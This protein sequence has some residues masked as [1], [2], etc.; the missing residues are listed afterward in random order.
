M[1]KSEILPEVVVPESPAASF[2]CLDT[3]KH[4]ESSHELDKGSGQSVRTITISD[5]DAKET[6]ARDSSRKTV[7]VTR[8]SHKSE[9]SHTP[10]RPTS[11]TDD[12]SVKNRPTAPR[13]WKTKAAVTHRSNLPI[14][15]RYNSPSVP[16]NRLDEEIYGTTSCP[17]T[18]ATSKVLLHQT[19]GLESTDEPS[20]AVFESLERDLHLARTD[21][22]NVE[23]GHRQALEAKEREVKQ[24]TETMRKLKR[25]HQK[26]KRA[27]ELKI[28]KAQSDLDRMDERQTKALQEKELQ[29]QQATDEIAKL[30]EQHTKAL[31]GKETELQH[32][33]AELDQLR[34]KPEPRNTNEQGYELANLRDEVATLKDRLAIAEKPDDE[35]IKYLPTTTNFY[36][37]APHLHPDVVS[38]DRDAKLKEIEKRPS[39]KQTFGKRLSNVR[40]ERGLYPH[41]LFGK[42]PT[43]EPSPARTAVAVVMSSDGGKVVEVEDQDSGALSESSEE[44]LSG[45]EKAMRAF[46]Q[47]MAVPNNPIPCLVDNQLAWRDGT[48]VCNFW[49]V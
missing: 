16:Q 32:A 41:Y 25:K 28:R 24:V 5:T 47:M 18:P 1:I 38:F 31:E 42:P 22:E 40:K 27:N 23:L 7:S 15:K 33:K 11:P 37:A 10:K 8:P 29:L 2:V 9:A 14:G 45:N 44:S 13:N 35:W 12:F 49:F 48:R 21:K 34:E 6:A 46:D 17:S 43:K 20:R 4:R 30:K 3:V 26:E 36:E 39:R 19:E